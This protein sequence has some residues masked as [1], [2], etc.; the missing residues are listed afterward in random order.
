MSEEAES[1]RLPL[2]VEWL[3]KIIIGAAILGAWGVYNFDRGYH[4][5]VDDIL[6]AFGRFA[7]VKTPGCPPS[8][9]QEEKG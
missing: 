2:I 8:L 7:E 9:T 6:C 1:K 4:R 5:G 3:A